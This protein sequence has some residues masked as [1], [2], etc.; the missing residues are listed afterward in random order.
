MSRSFVGSSSRMTLGSPMSSRR[1]CSRRRSPPDRS[2]TRVHCAPEEGP[3]VKPNRSAS[4]DAPIVLPP[5]R[6]TTLATCSTAS[7]TR[8]AGS[9]SATSCDR[10]AGLTVCPTTTRPLSGDCSPTSSRSSVDLPA[11][12][13]PTMPTRSPGPMFQSTPSSSTFLPKPSVTPC[14]SY[15]V[16]PSRAAEKRCSEMSSRAGGSSAMSALAASMRNCGLLVRAGGPRR[17]QA[18]SFFTSC[19]RFCSA[20]DAMRS[21]SARARTYAE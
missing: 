16:L 15:T 13:T 21:R 3:P 18:S 19:S 9:S 17:S 6:S 5:P 7:S 12:L 8:S 2:P 20:V 10:Y 14:S 4:E 1:I 11:P